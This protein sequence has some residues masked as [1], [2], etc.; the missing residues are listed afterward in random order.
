[1]ALSNIGREPRREI[2]EQVAGLLFILA[3]VGWCVFSVHLARMWYVPHHCVLYTDTTYTSCAKFDTGYFSDP[4]DLLITSGLIFG[5]WLFY[6]FMLLM[7]FFGEMVCDWLQAIGID[8]RPK[9]RY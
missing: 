1:M 8:P 3:Y 4:G 2:T 7:H 6:P 5:V 9:Q